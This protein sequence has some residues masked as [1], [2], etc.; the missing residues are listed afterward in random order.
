MRAKHNEEYK[1][2][3]YNPKLYRSIEYTILVGNYNFSKI[4]KSLTVIVLHNFS[5]IIFLDF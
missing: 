4:I 1:F 5:R 2:G 3:D